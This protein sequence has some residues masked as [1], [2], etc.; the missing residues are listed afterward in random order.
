MKDKWKVLTILLTAI[1]VAV[2]IVFAFMLYNA[3]E[4]KDAQILKMEKYG[5]Q[6]ENRL[7]AD[8]KEA[9][10]LK[11]KLSLAESRILEAESKL[12]EA[13]EKNKSTKKSTDK[14][15]FGY[16]AI[17]N[18]LISHPICDIWWSERGMASSEDGKDYYSLVEKYLEEKYGKVNG[19]KIAFTS[20]ETNYRDR[21]EFLPMLDEYLNEDTK[22]VTVQLSENMTNKDTF[23]RDYKELLKYIM[24]K[25][26]KAQII[27]VGDIWF[28]DNDR[29]KAEICKEMKLEYVSL[30]EMRQDRKYYCGM[31]TK[32]VG[33]DKEVHK[34]DH[35]GV[36]D[37]PGDRGMK[38][39][40]DHIIEKIHPE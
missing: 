40:A 10:E 39:I 9:K 35:Q 37:H 28:E 26:P 32:I 17:G 13:E 27:V 23:S 20:W 22:L 11:E 25:S 5:S 21:V 6:L 19:Q 12:K 15:G 18:S 31:G 2:I 38:Y 8:E 3:A 34:V 4:E 1:T 7:A 36:A 16:V 33:D 30:D 29:M 14:E 24:K